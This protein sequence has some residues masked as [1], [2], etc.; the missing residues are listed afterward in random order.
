MLSMSH[1][2]MP[3]EHDRTLPVIDHTNFYPP[4]E[5]SQGEA[6]ILQIETFPEHVS[7]VSLICDLYNFPHSP[8][9]V[10][11]TCKE[12]PNFGVGYETD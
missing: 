3:D 6:R 9:F 8:C 10:P 12:C 1:G 5:C 2:N 11:T 4:A 7:S